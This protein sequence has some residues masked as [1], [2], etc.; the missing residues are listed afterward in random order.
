MAFIQVGSW[1]SAHAR[2]AAPSWAP[3]AQTRRAAAI[4]FSV[5]VHLGLLWMLV[6]HLAGAI[7]Q[8]E[9]EV[10]LRV[11]DVMPPGIANEDSGAKPRLE[12]AALAAPSDPE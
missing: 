4:F 2:A 3:G 7:P 6:N 11:F 1:E 10:A 12:L 9:K 8:R 5:I